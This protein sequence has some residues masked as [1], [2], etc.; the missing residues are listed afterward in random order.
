ME[1]VDNRK[2]QRIALWSVIVGIVILLPTCFFALRSLP[3][4]QTELWRNT[5]EVPHETKAFLPVTGA[6]GW[7]FGEFLSSDKNQM[8]RLNDGR[9][10]VSYTAKDDP[11]LSPFRQVIV[12]ATKNKLIYQIS[13]SME[14]ADE[15]YTQTKNIMLKTLAEKYQRL[16]ELGQNYFG[17]GTNMVELEVKPACLDVVYRNLRLW[18]AL[19]SETEKKMEENAKEKEQEIKRSFK[20]L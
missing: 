7:K 19:L 2:L 15:D 4:P 9:Y 16:P 3:T 14:P 11:S 5:N 6:F 18:N 20:P 1:S 13:G 10:T 8:E 12:L 17:D